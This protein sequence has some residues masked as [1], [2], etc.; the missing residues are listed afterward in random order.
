MKKIFYVII[1]SAILFTSIFSLRAQDTSGTEFWVTFGKN[2]DAPY[3]LPNLNLQIRIASGNAL[4]T[5][6]IY[7]T[8]LNDAVSFSMSA[9]E[10]Y[11]YI[12][13]DA[14]K[15]TVYNMI[16]GTTN[17]SIHIV[18]DEPITVYALSQLISGVDATNILPVTALGTE[19]Y[20]ISYKGIELLEESYAVVA[21]QNNTN[22]YYNGYLEAT[23]DAGQVYYKINR[24][25]EMIGARITADYPVVFFAVMPLSVVPYG[26]FGG[27]AQSF[28]TT[29]S[30][31][32]YLG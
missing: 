30:V 23:L 20:Q 14:Q 31:G 15:P 13:D 12:L 3:V 8:H 27:G 6:T 25:P 7:F 21:T 2:N 1:V 32:K 9:H 19:Y 11:S 24:A 10:I 5:G 28:N 16:T 17:Y 18:S 26:N 4:T 29:I 22:L